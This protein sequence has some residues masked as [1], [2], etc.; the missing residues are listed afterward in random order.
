MFRAIRAGDFRAFLLA[1][2]G[3]VVTGVDMYDAVDNAEELEETA[4]LYF[5]LQNS[6]IKY[7]SEDEISQLKGGNK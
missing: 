5:L 1:N 6:K 3:P 2:H 7:L 4:K